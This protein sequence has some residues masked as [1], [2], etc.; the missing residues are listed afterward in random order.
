MNLSSRLSSV[1]ASPIRKLIPFAQK[2]KQKGVTVYHLNIGDPDIKTPV[3]MLRVLTQWNTPTI[4]YAQSQGDPAFLAAFEWYYHRLGY[5]FI[6]QN[7]I[8][9]TSGGSEGIG[10]ALFA[11]CNPGDSLLVFEPFYANYAYSS[12]IWDSPYSS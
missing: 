4:S 11:T 6:S 9:V 2:A 1:P 10:M 3:E 7:N 12:A 5:T 8:Q